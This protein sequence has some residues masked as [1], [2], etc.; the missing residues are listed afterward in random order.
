V[1]R[2][3]HYARSVWRPRLHKREFGGDI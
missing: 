3:D 1:L 2:S